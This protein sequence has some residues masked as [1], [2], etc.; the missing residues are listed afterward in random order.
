[1]SASSETVHLATPR[2][3]DAQRKW[4][5]DSPAL[6]EFLEVRKAAGATVRFRVLGRDAQGRVADAGAR[7][8]MKGFVLRVQDPDDELIYAAKI[9]V[10]EDYD[11]LRTEQ[12]EARLAAQLRKAQS[13]FAVPIHTGRVNR[14]NGMPG[15]QEEF[16][17]FVSEWIDGMTLEDWCTQRRSE[18]TG[19]FIVQVAKTVFRAINFLSRNNLKH[20]DLHWGNVMVRPP[21][22]DLVLTRDEELVHS[23]C[24][25]DMGS[26]K[27]SEQTTQKS[28]DDHLSMVNILHTL[29]NAAW[30]ERQLVA[31][32]PLFFKKLRLLLE[33][34]TDEDPSRHFPTPELF[35]AALDDLGLASRS[36]AMTTT[37]RTFG[38]FE[39]ISAEHL[40][41]D[42]T[43]LALFNNSLPWF[44]SMLETKPVVLSGPRG[45]GKSMLFR[46]L[47]APTQAKAAAK[48]GKPVVNSFGVYIGCATQLQNN[49]VW[50]A[51]QTGR[52]RQYASAISTYFQLV[53]ARELMRSICAVYRDSHARKRF[54]LREPVLDEWIAQVN[55]LFDQ[56]VES[57]RLPGESRVQHFADDLD[58]ACVRIHKDMLHG[59]PASILLPDTFLG[60]IT[61]KLVE[62]NP[63]FS[64]YPIVFLL[65]DYTEN[66]LSKDVQ[67]A[68]NRIVFERRSSHYFKVSCERMGFEAVDLDGVKIDAAR[69]YDPTDAGQ[70]AAEDC[71]TADAESFLTALID[72][73]LQKAN[74]AARCAQLLGS[75]KPY[76]KDL[77]LAKFIREEGSRQ[78]KRY[79]YYGTTHLARLWSGDIA[80]IL[81]TV[82]DMCIQGNVKPETTQQIPIS[83]Q[84]QSIV[85]I[86]KAYRSRVKD[87]HPYGMQLS[88]ILEAYGEFAKTVLI[89][90]SLN[91]KDEPRRTYRVEMTLPSNDGHFVDQLEA[92][93]DRAASIARELLRRSVFYPLRESRG[94]EGPA[95][96][97]IRWELR[98]IFRPSFGLSLEGSASYLDI[99]SMED[100]AALLI[101]PAKHLEERVMIY[102]QGR[103]N[104]RK[105]ASLFGDE[106]P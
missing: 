59:R 3:G 48:A 12:A 100:F 16:V 46:Y 102:T 78:G 29:H 87:L 80:T 101:E 79:Y 96:R 85:A 25:I 63:Q 77:A 105:T 67:S 83:V 66:R 84:H 68:L 39:G 50:I 65:D 23:L 32:A 60:S 14:F 94:K 20:D 73:R 15:P 92:A 90:G 41:D 37:G 45:C 2:L 70:Y 64:I 98:N 53:V 99:K 93:N 43:L 62:L 30:Q 5:H 86:S 10:P 89:K 35:V 42:E 58:R 95:T 52:V 75:S 106:Q 4:L 47:S 22:P 61:A 34:L 28:L 33:C 24:I 11:G 17:C 74:Y 13:L 72:Q 7:M 54:D 103:K 26:L 49:L 21:E 31:A 71:T 76:D 51:R 57:S 1:M 91:S 19:D 38:P 44:N 69:E 104:D 81:Q 9:C 56:S 40:A 55:H 88:R 6:P 27:P 36:D 97:T 18:L 8:G 82:K